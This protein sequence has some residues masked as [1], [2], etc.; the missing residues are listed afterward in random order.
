MRIVLISGFLGSGKTTLLIQMADYLLNRFAAPEI[1]KEAVG[2][3]LAII[4]NEIG[5]INLDSKLL[6]GQDLAMREMLSGCICCSLR[7]NLALEIHELAKT[8]NPEWLVIEATGLA[9]AKE[10]AEGIRHSLDKIYTSIS[11]LVVV[12]VNRLPY[13]L[14]RT[15]AMVARQ[16]EKVDVLILNKIDLVSEQEKVEACSA[17][18]KLCPQVRIIEVSAENGVAD[19]VWERI[20]A[21]LERR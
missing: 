13:L 18:K 6:K 21:A 2:K 15:K 8:T 14:D 12:D 3:K 17:L 5:S 10:V 11:S 1:A 7:D 4:E 16:L 9:S 19:D 20:F